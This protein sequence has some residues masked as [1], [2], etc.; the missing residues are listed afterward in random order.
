MADIEK[1]IKALRCRAYNDDVS[2]T[3]CAYFRP[4]VKPVL[5]CDYNQI[6]DDAITLLKEQKEKIENLMEIIKKA[7]YTLEIVK[8]KINDLLKKD[9]RSVKELVRCKDCKDA[10]VYDGNEVI[11]THIDSNGNDK[12]PADWFCADRKRKE[13]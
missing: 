8:E 11:C 6:F 10:I 13:T 5:K 9:G 1:V 2:C 4:D 12:H 3:D 7:D